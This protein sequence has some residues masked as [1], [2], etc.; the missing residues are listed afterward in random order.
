[1]SHMVI[2]RSSDGKPGFQ[3]TEDLADAAAFVENLR[4]EQ[5]VENARIY[6]LEQ[7]NFSFEP[8]Y[9]VRISTPPPPPPAPGTSAPTDAAPAPATDA[10][11]TETPGDGDGSTTSTEAT[12]GA[13]S[14]SESNGDRR[15][16]FGSR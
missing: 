14:S 15:G 8:Y 2:Y 12:A 13:V 11:T 10:S 5:N 4:N 7:V 9:Q 3:Q 1:M 6:R 16:L